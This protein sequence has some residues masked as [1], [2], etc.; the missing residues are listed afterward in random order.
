MPLSNFRSPAPATGPAQG[1]AIATGATAAI[2]T[3]G[4]E[5]SGTVQATGL[6][7]IL[8]VVAALLMASRLGG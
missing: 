3:Q 1:P 5:V 8:F 6:V 4:V 7:L 2:S